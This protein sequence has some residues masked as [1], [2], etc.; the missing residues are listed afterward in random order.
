MD[1]KLSSIELFLVAPTVEAPRMIGV[2]W[3]AYSCYH[4]HDE[5]PFH[6]TEEVK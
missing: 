5:L 4:Y 1:E 6:I 3:R 2:Y